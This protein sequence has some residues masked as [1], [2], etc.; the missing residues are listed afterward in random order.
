MQFTVDLELEKQSSKIDVAILL[1]TYNPDLFLSSQIESLKEQKGVNITIYWGDDGSTKES[2]AMT[3]ELLLGI[4]CVEFLHERVGFKKNFLLLLQQA[5][6]FEYYAFCD[7]DDI[8]LPGKLIRHISVLQKNGTAPACTHSNSVLLQGNLQIPKKSACQNHELKTLLAENCC[9]GATMVFNEQARQEVLDFEADEVV[10]HDWWMALVLSI[11]GQILYV[12]GPD[13]LY[14]QHSTNTIGHKQGIGKLKRFL[15]APPRRL[16]GQALNLARN[17][18]ECM[19]TDEIKTLNKFLALGK[20]NFFLRS[21]SAFI[22][23]HRR[24]AWSSEIL[25]RLVYMIRIA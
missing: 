4:K 5:A 2:I 20:T 10:A 8:W 15:D 18:S 24:R 25:R 9:Q 13:L 1:A 11:R 17:Y 22:D 12:E 14:R 19:Q 23:D 3:R 7:Q 6:G 16:H 21:Y